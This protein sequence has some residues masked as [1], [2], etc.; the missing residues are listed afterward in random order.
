MPTPT[1]PIQSA[2]R[3]AVVLVCTCALLAGCAA[4]PPAGHAPAPDPLPELDA[5]VQTGAAVG[6]ASL[7]GYLARLLMRAVANTRINLDIQAV[8]PAPKP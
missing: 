1:H 5:D 3:A 4:V 8:E 6:R 7:I 2:A